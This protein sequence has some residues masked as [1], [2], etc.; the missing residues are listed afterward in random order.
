MTEGISSRDDTAERG[1]VRVYSLSS[2]ESRSRQL[3]SRCLTSSSTVKRS[4]RTGISRLPSAGLYDTPIGASTMTMVHGSAPSPTFTSFSRGRSCLA[5]VPV[6]QR[7][8]PSRVTH[9]THQFARAS[10]RAP[11]ILPGRSLHAH[12]PSPKHPMLCGRPCGTSF[13]QYA[14]E[15]RHA[16]EDDARYA[17]PPFLHRAL[18]KLHEPLVAF[19]P[20]T[21]STG[22]VFHSHLAPG[23]C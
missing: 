1:I 13:S 10:E 23:T 6:I 16:L 7:G 15:A 12:T 19:Q 22:N 3:G 5:F 9:W 11:S 14:N 4:S 21:A 17:L 18:A 8:A 2:Y 20:H